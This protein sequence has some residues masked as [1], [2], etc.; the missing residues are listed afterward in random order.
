LSDD[1]GLSVLLVEDNPGERWLFAEI[2]RSRGHAVTAC[3]AGDEALVAFQEGRHQ[4]V[5]LDLILPGLDGLEVCRRI[6][7][8]PAG[9]QPVILVVTAKNEPDVLESVL[10]AGAN[11]YVAK[12]V[13]VAVLNIRLAVAERE[14]RLQAERERVRAELEVKSR[15]LSMLFS[16]LPSVFFSVDLM[17]DRLIQVS[18]AAGR[19]F[20]E[21]PAELPE[22]PKVWKRLLYPGT[23]EEPE[24]VFRRL[25]PGESVTH[26]A[27][28]MLDSE[29][30]CLLQ[31]TLTP[32]W[33]E[34]V[35]VRVDGVVS[36][37]TTTFKAQD[38]LG[39][40]NQELRSLF[41][42]SELAMQV[43]SF[44]AADPLLAGLSEMTGFPV[45]VIEE[46]DAERDAMVVVASHGIQKP[47]GPEPM[48]IRPVDT[49]ATRAIEKREPVVAVD[50]PSREHNPG[51]FT[52]L[53][54]RTFIGVPLVVGTEVLGVFVLCHPEPIGVDERK[55]RWIESLANTVASFTERVRAADDLRDREAN[56]RQIAEQLQRANNELEGFAYSV[57]H[58]LRAPLRTMTGFAHALV[59]DHGDQ[60]TASARDFAQRIITSGR[61][62]EGLISDLLSYSRLSFE[63]LELQPVE[64][65]EVVQ[66]VKEQ[67]GSDIT[68]RNATV[69]VEGELPTVMAVGA[70]LTQ[71]L[72]NLIS[73][74]I[75][76]VPEDRDPHVVI[77][78]EH[79]ENRVRIWVEDNGIGIPEGQEERI[80][81]VFE[82][83][84]DNQDVPGTGI[85]LAI[86]R[87]GVER[88]GGTTGVE[89]RK[90][91]TAFWFEIQE[92]R[93]RTWRPFGRRR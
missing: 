84:T 16:S 66:T 4:L 48:V 30:P 5:L 13:D 8:D 92:R 49:L 31:F 14:V 51:Y 74:A 75:K 23:L 81:R 44:E 57:S 45:V 9:E 27:E 6:R 10:D 38:E 26:R 86:V 50:P 39:I 82:R 53:K 80:F 41:E 62:A 7:A 52:S 70:I 68:E 60:L 24:E 91:G 78:P 37:V 73:N 67:L 22:K 90:N 61:R 56:Y 63:T 69:D 19:M 85:G 64:L 28:L 1:P 43:E 35:L 15:E 20:G 18:A 34:D 25:S 11:D 17:K 46:Y 76:F 77:R 47:D 12:P 2:L 33:E 29:G 79:R 54:L 88:I 83:L 55:L 3:E 72:S 36:D 71:V 42:I 32:H 40:R 93:T 89:H 21:D 65:K 59:E 87:R 58:D